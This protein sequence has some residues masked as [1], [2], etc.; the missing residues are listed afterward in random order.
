[1]ARKKLIKGTWTKDQVKLLKK[2]F[3]NNRTAEVAEHLNRSVD[4]VKKK[5]SRMGIRKSKRYMKT[6]GRA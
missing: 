1:M 3:P 4:T 2:E 5:A 6:L